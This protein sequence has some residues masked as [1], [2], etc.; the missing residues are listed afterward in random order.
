ML[1]I[2]ERLAEQQL[3][4]GT[5]DRGQPWASGQ[6]DARQHECNWTECECCRFF[7]PLITMDKNEIIRIARQIGTY[8]TSI[9]PFEDCCTLFVPKSPS[10]NP[11][12][13]VVEKGRSFNSRFG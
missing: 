2:A 5:R 4:A 6:P 7:A 1:R 9:L 11:N 13:K 10:T 3:G 12:L 8:D